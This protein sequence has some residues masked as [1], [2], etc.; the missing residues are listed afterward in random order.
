MV[1]PPCVWLCQTVGCGTQNNPDQEK[2]SACLKPVTPKV[3]CG[4]C[5]SVTSIPASNVANSVRS[6]HLSGKKAVADAKTAA[7]FVSEHKNEI[8]AAGRVAQENPELARAAA[9]GVRRAV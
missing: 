3:L 9:N 2:C 6:T 1:P 5:N 7:Q 8:Q 4:V